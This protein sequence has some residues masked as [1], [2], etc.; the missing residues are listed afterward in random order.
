MEVMD[1]PLNRAHHFGR[2][3]DQLVAK[4]KFEEAILCH[5]KASQPHL[6]KTARSNTPPHIYLTMWK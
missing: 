2:K 1:S 4:E 3:A 6:P 5:R